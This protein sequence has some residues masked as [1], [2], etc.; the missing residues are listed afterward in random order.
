MRRKEG[1]WKRK[2]RYGRR[3]WEVKM[4]GKIKPSKF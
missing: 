2:Y 1:Y 3:K 4:L